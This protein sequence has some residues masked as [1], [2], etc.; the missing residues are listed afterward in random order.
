[1]RLID[2]TKLHRK[3]GSVLGYSQP[4]LAGLSAQ[5]KPAALSPNFI[6]FCHPDGLYPDENVFP[7]NSYGVNCNSFLRVGGGSSGGIEGPGMPGTN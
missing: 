3:S 7:F 6:F 4:S 5:V 1:M 2:S